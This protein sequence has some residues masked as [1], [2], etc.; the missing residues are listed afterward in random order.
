M[1]VHE[2][3]VEVRLYCDDVDS[4]RDELFALSQTHVEKLSSKLGTG[5]VAVHIKKNKEV[6]RGLHERECHL[7]VNTTACKES[8]HAT[9]FGAPESV[10]SAFFKLKT[11]VMKGKEEKVAAKR[12]MKNFNE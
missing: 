11:V 2:S 3:E 9:E 7:S 10:R 1:A 8:I 4:A 6:F 12:T 5:Y